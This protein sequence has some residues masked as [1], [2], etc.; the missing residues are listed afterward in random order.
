LEQ[1]GG[2]EKS[3]A[4]SSVGSLRANQGGGRFFEE[5]DFLIGQNPGILLH[6]QGSPG[7][8]GGS[9]EDPE[10]CIKGR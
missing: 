2:V 8:K 6:D 10:R 5:L 3:I 7:W 4:F 9:C 1:R